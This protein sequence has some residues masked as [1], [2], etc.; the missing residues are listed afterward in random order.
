LVKQNKNNKI[1]VFGVLTEHFTR[2]LDETLDKHNRYRSL[3]F[4]EE[5]FR[6]VGVEVAEVG[7]V[8]DAYMRTEE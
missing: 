2:C 8:V 4:D 7:V 5:V 1:S 3:I 6:A